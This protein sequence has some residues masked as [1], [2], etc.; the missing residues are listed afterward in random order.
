MFTPP[1]TGYTIYTKS[2][3]PACVEVKK[4]LPEATIIDC[5]RYLVE[6]V[7]EFLDFMWSLPK[8]SGIT[9]FPMVFKD[10]EYVGGY[11]EL[12]FKTNVDF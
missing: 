6:D 10:G 11:K 9:S 4:L 5:D 8:A 2:Q 7:D 12:C 3:C 1:T